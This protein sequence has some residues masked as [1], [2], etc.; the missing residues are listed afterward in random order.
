MM[1]ANTIN[2]SD[3]EQIVVNFFDKPHNKGLII[4]APAMGVLQG[5]YHPLAKYLVAHGYAVI[6]FDFTGI[7]DSK[8]LK[9]PSTCTLK[10][11]GKRDLSTLIDYA[12]QQS[13]GKPLYLIG[14]SIS[15]Q[16]FPFAINKEKISAAFF[17]ASQNLSSDHWAGKEKFLAKLFW[18]FVLPVCNTLF[19]GLPGFTY[20]G[21]QKLPKNIARDWSRWG[22]SVSGA[23]GVE[24]EAKENYQETKVPASFMSLNDDLLLAPKPAVAAL[25]DAFGSEDKQHIHLIPAEEGFSEIGHF[26][27]FKRKNQ[28]LWTKIHEWFSKH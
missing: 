5:F 1:T 11:W 19:N 21:N 25:F 16:I 28:T 26:G 7:G 4:I 20:G 27:F 8:I 9:S 13:G 22:R 3:G 17:V 6:T 23:L 15:G 2:T 18:Y 24:P 14:H 10:N 12:A